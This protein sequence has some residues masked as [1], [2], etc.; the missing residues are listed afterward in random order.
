MKCI[1]INQQNDSERA[2]KTAPSHSNLW[3][4]RKLKYSKQRPVCYE[5]IIHPHPNNNLLLLLVTPEKQK[6]LNYK[7]EKNIRMYVYLSVRILGNIFFFPKVT[8]K[9]KKN[10]FTKT[11]LLPYH[12]KNKS[13]VLLKFFWFLK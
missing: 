10:H 8:I 9:K 13:L 6:I 1:I 11:Y 4:V 3:S 2:L 12:T 5:T 7:S